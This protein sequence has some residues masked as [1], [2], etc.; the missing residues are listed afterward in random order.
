MQNNVV[1]VVHSTYSNLTPTHI[2]VLKH[3]AMHPEV[4]YLVTAELLKV[5]EFIAEKIHR[6]LISFGLC[7]DLSLIECTGTIDTHLSSRSFGIADPMR[8]IKQFQER[9]EY[10]GPAR[11]SLSEFGKF[12]CENQFKENSEST[13]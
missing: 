7:L 6:D 3:F 8:N 2:Q 10:R 1:D 11:V 5:D 12:F 13:A 4:T 9:P